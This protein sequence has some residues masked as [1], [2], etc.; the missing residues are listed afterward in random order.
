MRTPTLDEGWSFSTRSD[1]VIVGTNPEMADID[2]PRGAIF[3]L[4]WYVVASNEYG[5][6]RELCV[7]SSTA[8]SD[9]KATAE[10][11]ATRLGARLLNLRKLPVG[12]AL[13]PEGRPVYGSDAYVEYG[14]ADDLALERREA[15][16]ERMGL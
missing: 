11:L 12:F 16:D 14:Q 8:S 7:V 13:W 9:T 15:D 6:T 3:G 2:N 4:L 1:L 5:D 10:A